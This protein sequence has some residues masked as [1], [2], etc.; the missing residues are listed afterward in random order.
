MVDDVYNVYNYFSLDDMFLF[1]C[2][3]IVGVEVDKEVVI[4]EIIGLF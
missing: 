3:G 2:M 4:E 1:I